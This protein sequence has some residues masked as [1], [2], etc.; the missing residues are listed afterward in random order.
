MLVL[1]R[2]RAIFEGSSEARDGMLERAETALRVAEKLLQGRA[3]SR[4]SSSSRRSARIWTRAGD[5]CRSSTSPG[6]RPSTSSTPREVR[7][8]DMRIH[9]VRLPLETLWRRRAL[10]VSPAWRRRGLQRLERRR[11]EPPPA[12][13]RDFIHYDTARTPHDFIKI[14]SVKAV[15]GGAAAILTGRVTLT[16]TTPSGWHHPSTGARSDPGRSWATRSGPGSP[17][18]RF[19]PRTSAA[20]GRSAKVTQDLAVARRRSS[21]RIACKPTAPSPR[22]RS[23]NSRES[24]ARPGPIER[25][26]APS[27]SRWAFRRPTRRSTSRC[28]AQIAGTVVERNV[29]VGQEVRA[30]QATPLL[31]ISNL[32]TVWVLAD[33]Y[34]QDL[35]RREPAMRSRSPC[36]RTP[37]TPSPEGS[38]TSVTCWILRPAP[39]SFGAWCRTPT[40]ASSP[41][42]SPRYVWRAAAARADPCTGQGGPERW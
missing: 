16:R 10:A 31:T 27:S 38:T 37:A 4:C 22:K 36:R 23:R 14:E 25:A 30:D 3:P 32:D 29:L 17:S 13:D 34:E 11:G 9:R 5:T 8:N 18:S 40:R 1:A 35:W 2:S 33:V 24:S 42:C 21:A 15:P 28:D 26:R 19:R 7:F 6:R 12:G 39:S 41:T 20:P